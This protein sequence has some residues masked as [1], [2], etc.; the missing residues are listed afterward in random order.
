MVFFM[1][2]LPSG[3]VKI[4]LFTGKIVKVTENGDYF[5]FSFF[6]CIT[7]DYKLWLNPAVFFELF[8]NFH[9]F[10]LRG[11]LKKGG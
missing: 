10:L 3:G 7:R 4:A 5:S 6:G 9:K 2:I 8:H 11:T 1:V